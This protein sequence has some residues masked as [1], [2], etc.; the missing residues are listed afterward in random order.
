MTILPFP[1]L[2]CIR[3]GI[4]TI[5]ASCCRVSFSCHG[6]L[7]LN[8][9]GMTNFEGSDNSP[10][11]KINARKFREQRCSKVAPQ[12][13]SK[14]IHGLL[15]LAPFPVQSVKTRSLRHVT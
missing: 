13:L 1:N 2:A 10:L 6:I 9:E 3:G 4:A 14:K 15:T 11:S 12:E 8:F 7:L 5:F